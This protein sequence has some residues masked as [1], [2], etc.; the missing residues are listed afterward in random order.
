MFFEDNF[1]HFSLTG[2]AQPSTDDFNDC[3]VQS[4]RNVQGPFHRSHDKV[5]C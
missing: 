3:K 2:S 1:E 4:A 5:S